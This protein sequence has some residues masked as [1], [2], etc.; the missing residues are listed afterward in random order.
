MARRRRQHVI[1][2]RKRRLQLERVIQHAATRAGMA[3]L[4]AGLS[5]GFLGRGDL[6]FYRWI[7]RHTPVVEVRAPTHL[8]SLAVLREMPVHRSWLWCP[9]VEGRIGERILRK[10]PEIRA[11]R[12]ANDFMEDRVVVRLEPRRPLVR[13]QDCGM[14]AEGVVFAVAPEAWTAL[15]TAV[16]PVSGADPVVGRWMGELSRVPEFWVVWQRSTEIHTAI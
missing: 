6:H 14:D 4:L 1:L 15:P 12:F 2:R 16:F 7:Q 11:V 8:G 5:I 13:W 10:F 3:C 9:G